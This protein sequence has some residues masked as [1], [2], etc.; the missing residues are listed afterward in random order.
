MVPVLVLFAVG[1]VDRIAVWQSPETLWTAALNA[2]PD[3][4]RVQLKTGRVRLAHQPAEALRLSEDA[5]SHPDTRIQREGHELA[6]RALLLLPN[7][8]HA[9]IRHHLTLA[10]DMDDPEA[11]WACAARCVWDETASNRWQMC[12]TAV[13]RE[14]A[15]GDVYNTM[16]VIRASEQD[17]LGAQDWFALAVQTEPHRSEFQDNLAK[18]D[19]LLK[20]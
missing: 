5:W 16:G 10:A 3:D 14:A 2:N 4:P 13:N 20:R 11:G 12:Q 9:A 6:A 17:L 7:V 1:Q 8:A 15:T 18:A 19:R